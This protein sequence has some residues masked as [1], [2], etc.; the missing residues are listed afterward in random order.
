[1]N[2]SLEEPD[3]G[4]V[5][6]ENQFHADLVMTNAG[7]RLVIVVTQSLASSCATLVLPPSSRLMD[8]T[9]TLTWAAQTTFAERLGLLVRD[10]DS[11][12]FNGYLNTTHGPS[13]LEFKLRSA[14]FPR[15]TSFRLE[16][17]GDGETQAI[18]QPVAL[19]VGITYEV[20]L[21]HA[22]LQPGFEPCPPAV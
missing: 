12:E 18:Q 22:H 10:F 6:H 20:D 13:P 15:T 8:G 14:D 16:P 5:V 3:G 21:E 2:D 7:T 4:R 11:G 1:V 9:V 17:T 19:D